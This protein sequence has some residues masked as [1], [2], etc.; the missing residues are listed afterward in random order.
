MWGDKSFISKGKVNTAFEAFQTNYNVSGLG[1]TGRALNSAITLWIIY[2]IGQNSK[3]VGRTIACQPIFFLKRER[4]TRKRIKMKNKYNKNYT[5]TGYLMKY[6]KGISV[7]PYNNRVLQ[8]KIELPEILPLIWRRILIPSDYNLWDLHVAIQDSMGWLDYHLHHF[9]FKGKGKNKE[10]RIGIPDFEGTDEM[11]EVYPGWEIPVL[12][13]FNDLG[14]TAKY[15]YDY[16]DSWWHTVQL[17]GYYFKDK[18]VSYPICIDGERA[19]PPED[20]GGERGYYEMIKTLSDVENEDYEE[21]KTWVG[22]NWHF[23]SF[24]KYAIQ[25]DKPYQ[26]WKKAFLVKR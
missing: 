13:Y 8:F 2:I 12:T 22:K 3:L 17:E 6:E 26:R 16:G 7:S 11:P 20:C 19:C 25:F 14:I 9:E 4:S 5:D 1:S 21:M 18:K 24:D 23:D 10:V 15:F